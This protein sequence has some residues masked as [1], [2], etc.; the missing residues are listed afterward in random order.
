MKQITITQVNGAT[1][2]ESRT[3]GIYSENI[4]STREVSGLAEIV[5]AETLDRRIKP[6][7]YLTTNTKAVIDGFIAGAKSDL[8]VYKLVLGGTSVLTVQDKYIRS[9]KEAQVV[10]NGTLTAC[11]EV[12]YI[13]GAFLTKKVY[14]SNSLA[15]LADPVVTTTTTTAAATTTTTTAAATTTT[16]AAATTT[17]TA[18][19]TTTTTAA[20]TTT[21]TAAATTTTTVPV[22]TTTTTGA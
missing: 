6:E 19:A 13:E 15:S 7:T 18:A 2:V 11:R 16:T 12:K 10:V 20:A 8:V 14:V 17:T 4:V 1:L 21:T 22:T 3:I 9:I 5:Y